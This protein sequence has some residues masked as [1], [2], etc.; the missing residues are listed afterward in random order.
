M[1]RLWQKQ[2]NEA[3]QERR[4]HKRVILTSVVG[5]FITRAC[6]PCSMTELIFRK[7]IGDDL[8]EVLPISQLAP[9]PN[10]QGRT[11]L[12]TGSVR[13]GER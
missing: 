11:R 2:A 5:R 1:P 9:V 6:A 13:H 4:L 12:E 10:S 8:P 3:R 7:A